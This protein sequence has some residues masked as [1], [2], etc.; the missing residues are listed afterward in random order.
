MKRDGARSA[1]TFVFLAQ[2][3]STST[4]SLGVIVWGF[5]LL[6]KRDIWVLSVSV[7]IGIASTAYSYLQYKRRT[8]AIAALELPTNQ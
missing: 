8:Q 5:F 1:Y 7:F 4:L 6:P 3:L 2:G